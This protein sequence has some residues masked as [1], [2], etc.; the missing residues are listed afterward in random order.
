VRLSF[1][2]NSRVQIVSSLKF[3]WFFHL[4]VLILLSEFILR[5]P[6]INNRLPAPELTLWHMPLIQTKMDY[7]KTFEETRGIDVLFIGNSTTQAGIDPQ[8][9][10]KARGNSTINSPGAFNGS[11]EGLPPYGVLLFLEIYLKY[12]QPE[13][14][15][16]GLT[17]Q[18]LNSNSPWAHD[19]VSRLKRSPMALAEAGRGFQGHMNAWFLKNSYLY[20]Y[21]FI[22][23]Q[24]LLGGEVNRSRTNVYFDD[25]GYHPIK[26][27]LS[28]IP[29]E[30]RGGFY[31]KAGVLNYSTEGEQLSSLKR[32]IELCKD[33]NIP[34]ILVNMPLAE[35]YNNNFDSLEDYYLYLSTVAILANET[36]IP[37][38]NMGNFPE[39]NGFKDNHF[40]DFNHLNL[41]G[42][43]KLSQMIG[44]RF[45]NLD[46][47]LQNV[48]IVH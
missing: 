28:D 48:E 29:K 21:R 1:T 19:V 4:L 17:P 9:F 43:E 23:H 5:T 10:D 25:R 33:K 45:R 16:Y 41:S 36:N 35:D 11:L 30:E 47:E 3:Y 8:A 2:S 24:M 42:A 46:L 31:N 22:L 44:M 15:I 13:I 27:K 26:R 12:T 18:D 32:L 14:I 6:I 39:F 20:R 38:W 37:Y 7:L 40:G 34:L